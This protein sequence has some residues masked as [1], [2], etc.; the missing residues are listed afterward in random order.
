MGQ[1]VEFEEPYELLKDGNSYFSQLVERTGRVTSKQLFQVAKIAHEKRL[2]T[3]II[4]GF[5]FL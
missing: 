4:A 2:T 5:V 3:W 1:I